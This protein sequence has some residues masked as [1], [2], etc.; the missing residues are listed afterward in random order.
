MW[1]QTI[2]TIYHHHSFCKSGA[3]SDLAGLW[4]SQAISWVLLSKVSTGVVATLPRCSSQSKSAPGRSC[5]SSDPAPDIARQNFLH[6]TSVRSDS[7]NLTHT[8]GEKIWPH[9]LKGG[10]AK[11]LLA[12]ISTT[13]R[14]FQF[15]AVKATLQGMFCVRT[16]C[17]FLCR[18]PLKASCPAWDPHHA[19]R[20]A[21]P[22][23]RGPGRLS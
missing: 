19:R 4:L 8:S 12:C 18:L 2:I 9:L 20:V 5:P 7:Q 14:C 22:R 17:A 10:A 23:G 6:V 13:T 21:Q 15:S 11:N 16:T 3:Q 1:L